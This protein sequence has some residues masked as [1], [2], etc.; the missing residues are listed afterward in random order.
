[1][2]TDMIQDVSKADLH[3][4]TRFSADGDSSWL[5]QLKFRECWTEPRQVYDLALRRG[6]DFVT[7]TDHDTIEGALSIA[8]LDRF[9]IGEEITKTRPNFTWSCLGSTRTGIARFSA[10][11]PTSTN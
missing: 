6:M 10:S 1:M 3:V 11:G 7:I 9:F 2:D 5:K 4:H 8:H